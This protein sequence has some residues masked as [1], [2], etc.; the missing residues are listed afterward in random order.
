MDNIAITSLFQRAGRFFL[1][2]P[3][4]RNNYESGDFSTNYCRILLNVS[5]SAY[6]KSI[7]TTGIGYQ[8]NIDLG[9]PLSS[10]QQL[11][12]YYGNNRLL[13]NFQ[14]TKKPRLVAFN[15]QNR[16]TAEQDVV[17]VE[18]KRQL[19]YRTELEYIMGDLSKF[20]G[21]NKRRLGWHNY[22]T[23]MPSVT[24]EVGFIIHT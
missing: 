2:K 13:F 12:Q 8:R 6:Q 3:V 10:S 24:N 14:L 11:L 21:E 22:L 20:N 17:K 5:G 9:G 23:Y 15:Y 1:N 4:Q 18:V 16:S 19:T 7:I